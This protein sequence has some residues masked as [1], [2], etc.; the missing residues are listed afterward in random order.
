[1]RRLSS[2]ALLAL[3]VAGLSPFQAPAQV[4]QE[5]VDLAVIEQIREEGFERSQVKQMAR[6]LT[7][8]IGPRLSGSPGM[9]AAN[10][11]TNSMFR[12]W[13][14]ANATIEPWGEFG[15]GWVHED[16][17][18]RI[19]TPFVQPLHG[20]PMAWTGSTDGLVRGQALVVQAE[21]VEDLEQYRGRLAGTFLLVESL[22]DFEPEFE[23]R[24]RRSSLESLLEPTKV[25][26][27]AMSDDERAAFF[28]RM[29]AEREVRDAIYAF[30]EQEGAL[31]VLRISSR[32][33]GVIRGS[34]AGSREAGAPEGLPHVALSKEQYNQIYR[35]VSAGVPVELELMVQNRFLED[36]LRQYNSL[37]DITGTDKADEYVMLGAHLDS[38]HMG[39]GATDNAAG[40]VIMME[41]MRI[42]K[43]IGV[44][45]RRTIRIALWSGE[46]QGLLGSR[47]WVANHPE[48][49]DRI[50]A[51]VNI[52]NGTGRVRGIWTQSNE[53]VVSVFEQVLWPFRDLG[54]VAVRN[55]NTGGTDHLAFDAA[56]IPG[57]NFI[58]DPIE[59]GINTHH[60]EL[61]TF[62]HLVL[63]DLRQAAVVVAS[64]VYA[65][66]MRE[67]MVPRKGERPVS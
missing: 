17:K 27:N 8:V 3:L 40:S 51:Y 32:D 61:D 48:L 21:S 44:E 39:G 50:S 52:D 49:H 38:W 41:A 14:L 2:T 66:S 12:E 9:A 19:L 11:W 43:E 58:Q 30:A 54:V 63:D 26:Q 42:L 37:A 64:T 10:E 55:G 16:Y 60:T 36:D 24:D 46:E 65:L 57:F 45:P 31:A 53:Q 33:D 29:R 5:A 34:S 35:N 47:A 23:H 7:E 18:G 59:Y 62:D 22:Q 20:Q 1:M 28:A 25:Q 4:A 56:G 15:R 67:E 13:G 6:H